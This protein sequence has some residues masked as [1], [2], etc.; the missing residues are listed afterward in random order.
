L[1]LTGSNNP[2]GIT[3]CFDKTN[4]YPY[5]YAKDLLG[6]FIFLALFLFFLIVGPNLLGHPD[7]YIVA[8]SLVTPIHIVPE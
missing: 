3:V 2:L 6:F 8:N 5:F 4:F 1:H 7:N